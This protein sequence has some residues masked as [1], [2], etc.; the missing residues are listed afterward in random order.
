M[1]SAKK[2]MDLNE[3]Y[4]VRTRKRVKCSLENIEI[5]V[6]PGSKYRDNQPRYQAVGEYEA[7]GREPYS[8]YK[9]VSKDNALKL[10]YESE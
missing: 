7:A 2:P 9:F 5:K 4:D 8:V 1:S 10:G 3:F 6:I